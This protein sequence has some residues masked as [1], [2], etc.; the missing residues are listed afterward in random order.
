MSVRVHRRISEIPPSEWDALLDD[1]ATP[2]VSFGF[3]EALEASGCAMPRRGWTPRHL[4]LVEAGKLQ[5]AM[6]AYVKHDL[7]G[8]D[9][10]RDFGF[11]QALYPKL[12]VGVPITPVTGRRILVARGVDRAAAASR[13]LDAARDLCR[14]EGLSG[15]QVLFPDEADAALLEG[16]GLHRRVDF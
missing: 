14:E 9:F 16:L 2:F 8:A 7:D 3:L 13:L 1:A 6:P 10:A 5:A 12:V 15:V 11:G 4:T